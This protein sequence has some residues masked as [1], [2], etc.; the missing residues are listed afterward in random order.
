AGGKAKQV[1]PAADVWALGAIL[2]R[3]LTGRPPFQAANTLDTILQIVSDEPTPLRKRRPDVPRALETICHKC[4]TK[5]PAKRYATAAALADDLRRWRDGEPIL[6]RPPGPA[7]RLGRWV[8]RN[9][10]AILGY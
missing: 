10:A 5:D 2:Y 3:M 6:A 7:E 1:G 8:K 9:Q 4:L